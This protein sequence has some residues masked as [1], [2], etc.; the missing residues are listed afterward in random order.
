MGTPLRQPNIAQL[1]LKFPN[2]HGRARGSEGV[3]KIYK[4]DES[5]ETQW[6]RNGVGLKT[7]NENPIN[8]TIEILANG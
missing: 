5:N 4:W 1:H 2:V 7:E 3:E 8:I 6:T